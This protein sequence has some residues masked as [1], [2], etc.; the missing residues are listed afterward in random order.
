MDLRELF[1]NIV[2]PPQFLLMPSVG[3]DVSDASLKY[4]RFTQ[5]YGKSNH[6]RLEA[7]GDI[8]LAPGVVVEGKVQD[9][10]VLVAELKKIRKQLGVSFVRVS[11]PEKHAYIFETEIEPGAAPS[12]I[13]GLLEFKLE[14]NVPISPREAFFDY[15]IIE[16]IAQT[17]K[18]RVVVTV[19]G[20]ETVTQYH[21]VCVAAGFMP[22]SFEVEAQAIARAVTTQ[23]EHHSSMIIDFG[24]RHTGVGIVHNGVL[25]HAFAS[26]VGGSTLSQVMRNVL[27]SE[28]TE[29]ELTALKNKHGLRNTHTNRKVRD[30]LVKVVDGLADEFLSRIQYWNDE[31]RAHGDREVSEV[32][33]C[34][35][36]ANLAG[37]PEYLSKTLNIPTR[38][39]S[40][41]QNAFSTETFIPPI[42]EPHS[43]GYATAIGLALADIGRLS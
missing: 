4:V 37:L 18:L 36:S 40:V 7:C 5:A 13:R 26:D 24:E 16:H 14:E 38:R 39:A 32:I 19:Y 35:G 29:V 3:I 22:L 30:A 25:V 31:E 21:D 43:Y 27:G 41:W 28:Q 9:K 23:S 1:T 33:L 34:G 10:D 11:L 17:E 12:E 20:K 6:I 8:P 2:P 42:D 15:E